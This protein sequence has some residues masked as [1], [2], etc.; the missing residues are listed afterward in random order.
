MYVNLPDC[1]DNQLTN[2][3]YL[4]KNFSDSHLCFFFLQNNCK[5]TQQTNSNCSHKLLNT[6]KNRLL[7]NL[8]QKHLRK[9][10]NNITD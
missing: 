2:L 7:V 6:Q 1:Y 9:I 10:T 3:F 4:N 5:F 8:K